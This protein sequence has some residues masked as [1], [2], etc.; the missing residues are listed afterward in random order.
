VKG[1]LLDSNVVIELRKS[2]PNPAVYQWSLTQ[3]SKDM[4]ISTLVLGEHAQGIEMLEPTDP[5]RVQFREA[6]ALTETTFHGRVLPIT[7]EVAGLWGE[8]SGR[9][10]R[11]DQARRPPPAVDTLMLATA[12]AHKLHFVTRNGKDVRWSGWSVFD[13]WVDDPARYPLVR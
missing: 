11:Q 6:L 3:F 12:M 5:R 13:P 1:W 8:L 10:R 4:F 9:F 2:H 7:D